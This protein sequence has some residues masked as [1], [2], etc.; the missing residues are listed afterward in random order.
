MDRELNEKEQQLIDFQAK[1]QE[2]G[3]WE[4]SAGDHVVIS[5]GWLLQIQNGPGKR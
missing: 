1:Q 3:F 5:E 2:V 4:I